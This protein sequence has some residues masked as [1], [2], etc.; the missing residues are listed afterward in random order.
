MIFAGIENG[1][2]HIFREIV[3]VSINQEIFVPADDMTV[4]F[5]YSEGFPKLEKIYALDDDCGDIEEAILRREV[6]FEGIV[7]EQ[8]FKADS[9]GADITVYARSMAALL[10]DNECEPT[11]YSSPSLDVVYFKHLRPFGVEL[12][13]MKTKC[14][15]GSL[16]I[17]KGSSHYRVLEKFCN[18]FLNSVPRIDARGFC[19]TDV[20]DCDDVIRFDNRNGVGF[21][22]I[23][24]S[25]N[26]YSRIS[27]IHVSKNGGYDTTLNDEE[28]ISKGI[29]RERYMCL[30]DSKTGTLSDAY[31]A[32]ESGA[33]NSFS[34]TLKCGERLINTIG[35]RAEVDVRG[36]ENAELV[37][38]QVKYKA[39]RNGEYTRVKLIPRSGY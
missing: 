26:R 11:E 12:K 29:V 22:Y 18:E 35:A 30:L 7:D 4:V 13:D 19:R 3:S 39:D 24:I 37:V 27:K 17:T 1:E 16:R 10:L 25:D 33:I 38:A 21:S 14:R 36:C 23:S 32:I 5:P 15:N 2:T 34:V 31:E 8:V 6:L 28:S 9:D 20:F